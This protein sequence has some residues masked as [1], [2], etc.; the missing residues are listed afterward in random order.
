LEQVQKQVIKG[1]IRYVKEEF[2][3][4]DILSKAMGSIVPQA[5]R[6]SGVVNNPINFIAR[7]IFGKNE[8]VVSKHSDS[9]KGNVLRNI[10]L[11][12]VEG[13]AAYLI[14]KAIKRRF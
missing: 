5:V 12:L 4:G 13:T 2:S 11:G 8:N 6:R 3:V 7:T 1:D 9:G 10:A 14:A